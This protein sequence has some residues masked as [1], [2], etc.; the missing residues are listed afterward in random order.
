MG[1]TSATPAAAGAGN[2]G[3]NDDVEITAEGLAREEHRRLLELNNPV[4]EPPKKKVKERIPDDYTFEITYPDMEP[5]H[6]DFMIAADL[7]GEARM[8]ADRA[9]NKNR[10]R[11]SPKI[12]L[13][14]D[15]RKLR[16]GDWLVMAEDDFTKDWLTNYFQTEEFCSKFKATLAS[17]R[18]DDYKYSV[19]I[20]PPDSRTSNDELMEYIL[21][22]VPDHGYIRINKESRFY[23][24]KDNSGNTN[25]AYYKSLKKGTPFDDGGVPYVKTLWLR[26]NA[27]AHE[28]FQADPTELNIYF[29]SGKIDIDQVKDKKKK[30]STDKDKS[31]ESPAAGPDQGSSGGGRADDDDE[32]MNADSG[33]D[34]IVTV[35]LENGGQDVEE[36]E[37]RGAQGNHR[38]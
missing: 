4:P 5:I 32:D 28:L 33:E 37:S 27:Q 10:A 14:I 1:P 13:K 18:G 34:E 36:D 16:C 12:T 35:V 17:E 9:R 7:L 3:S 11:G 29:R 21:E 23:K 26:M 24:D 31:G 20:Q 19:K 2:V 6:D 8:T 38:E 25:K 30:K 15:S 22:D